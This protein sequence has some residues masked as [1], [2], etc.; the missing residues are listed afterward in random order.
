MIFAN[1]QGNSPHTL[2]ELSPLDETALARQCESSALR[3]L[4]TSQL[5]PT[6]TGPTKTKDRRGLKSH[7]RVQG[8]HRR[9]REFPEPLT[10]ASPNTARAFDMNQR[11]LELIE[12]EQRQPTGTISVHEVIAYV[13]SDRYM[14]LA[15]TLEYLPLSE[16]NIRERLSEIPHYRVG[17]RLLFKKSELDFW[18]QGYREE[19][20]ELAIRAIAKQA[21]EKIRS[22]D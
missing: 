6:I 10:G 17:K 15:Q 11:S 18:M 5:G 22:D 8:P 3:R 16:R 20:E 13:Q 7:G 19:T 1:S 21:L 9:G 12:I 14:T 4:E 2:D